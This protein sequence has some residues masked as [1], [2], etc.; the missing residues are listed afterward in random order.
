MDYSPG[1]FFGVRKNVLRKVM[2]LK[3]NKMGN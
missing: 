1:F 3:V 2:N